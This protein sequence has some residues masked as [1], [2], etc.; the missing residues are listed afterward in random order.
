[1]PTLAR[2]TESAK[3]SRDRAAAALLL[4]FTGIYA[5]VAYSV[6]QRAREFDIRTALGARASALVWLVI[7]DGAHYI[8]AGVVAGLVMAF[9]AMRTLEATL[10]GLSPNDPAISWRSIRMRAFDLCMDPSR[11]SRAR[12]GRP[13]FRGEGPCSIPYQG[14]RGRV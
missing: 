11:S 8:A 13:T 3:A 4:A 7:A 5:V 9:G 6:A 2:R 14:R 12:L 10:F 1:M